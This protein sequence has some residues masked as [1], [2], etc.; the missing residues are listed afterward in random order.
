MDRL[1]CNA[2]AGA[3]DG[4]LIDVGIDIRRFGGKRKRCTCGEPTGRHPVRV[5]IRIC[6]GLRGDG[7]VAADGYSGRMGTVSDGRSDGG[8]G[9]GSHIC[10]LTGSQQPATGSFTIG[11]SHVERLGMNDKR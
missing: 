10:S 11:F 7:D 8:R 4:A 5:R 6:F 1:K 9:S 2:A 3:G